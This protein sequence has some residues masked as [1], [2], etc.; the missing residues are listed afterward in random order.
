MSENEL[1]EIVGELQG[2]VKTLEAKLAEQVK[3]LGAK[4]AELA[5]AKAAA[6]PKAEDE[7]V[8]AKLAQADAI[9]K[10][11]ATLKAQMFLGELG[12]KYPDV[13]LSLLSPAAPEAMENQAK[14]LQAM[15]TKAVAAKAPPAPGAQAR[16]VDWSKLP[17]AD[18][19]SEEQAT[20]AELEE[21]HKKVLDAQKTGD[22]G[23]VLDAILA[24]DPAGA[25]S[26]MSRAARV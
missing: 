12:K 10:E 13:D 20:K 22:V 14:G 26:F 3:S 17:K 5:A 6:T 4:E 7:A 9:A 21:R 19:P 18:Q 24:K 2:Q 25:K 8:K 23:Q 15:V 1:D 16:N 11:N